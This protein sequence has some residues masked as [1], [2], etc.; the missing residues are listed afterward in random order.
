MFFGVLATGLLFPVF[1]EFYQSTAKGAYTI[2]QLTGLR[3]G[4]IVLIIVAF[5]MLGFRLAEVLERRA[6]RGGLSL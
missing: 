1:E 2:P 5:G 3:D 4:V 6:A